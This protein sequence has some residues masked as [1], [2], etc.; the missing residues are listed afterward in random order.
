[1]NDEGSVALDEALIEAAGFWSVRRFI[2]GA[3]A[4]RVEPGDLVIVVSFTLSNPRKPKI[5]HL[6]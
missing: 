5:T 4:R 6:K 2:S 3:A 1:M